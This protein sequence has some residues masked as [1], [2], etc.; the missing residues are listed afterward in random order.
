MPR[1]K[2]TG[3]KSLSEDEVLS[4]LDFAANYY[5]TAIGALGSNVVT[6]ELVNGALQ[7]ITNNPLKPKEDEINTALG[8]PINNEGKLTGM[9][10]Y[11]EMVD[12]LVKRTLYYMSSLPSFDMTYHCVNIEDPR[13]YQ[14]EEYKKDY[15]RMKTFFSKFNYKEQFRYVMREMMRR[16][17]AYYIFRDD[18]KKYTFQE[19]PQQYCKI[20][21]KWD[22]GLLYDFNMYWFTQPGVDIDMYP[23]STKKMLAK[24]YSK[25]ANQYDPARPIGKRDTT[26]SYWVQADPTQGY[27]AFKFNVDNYSN[28]PYLSGVF[29]DAILRPLIRKLQTNQYILAAQKVMVG[30]IPLIKDAKSGS[31]RDQFAISPKQMGI[32][33]GLLKQG[34]SDSLKVGGVPFSD[35]KVLDFPVSDSS[36]YST[37]GSNTAANTGVTSRIIHSSDKMTAAEV[38]AS[39]QVDAM[40]STFVYPIFSNFLEYQVN[41]LT[42]KYK[43]AFTFEG[44]SFSSDRD[45]RF[46][47]WHRNANLGIVLPQKLAAA[48]GMTPFEFEDQLQEAK[49]SGFSNYLVGLLNLNTANTQKDRQNEGGRPKVGAE[50]AA[51]STERKDDFE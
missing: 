43:F 11:F 5:N 31:V 26:W 36:M 25:D 42:K 13:E 47:K 32:Y 30:L 12:T 37:Y 18:C 7:Q 21:G 46:E 22:Y 14:S 35:V 17:T 15:K 27:W 23:K 33:L 20:T 2:E 44:N 29:P 3:K 1:N 41:S 39:K 24:V 28:V 16:E 19:L 48:M 9:M 51:D 6:P 4:V 10:E 8:D 50:E 40:I 34:L 45:S 49:Y 38:E